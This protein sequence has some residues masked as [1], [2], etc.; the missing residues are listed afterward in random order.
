MEKSMGVK[1]RKKKKIA[2]LRKEYDENLKKKYAW[3]RRALTED[4]KVVRR[5][6]QTY[7]PSNKY[8]LTQSK[9]E[10]QEDK[11]AKT[12]AK[13]DKKRELKGKPHDKKGKNLRTRVYRSGP[14]ALKK[15]KLS[16]L[17]DRDQ[18]EKQK[19]EQTLDWRYSR[20]DLEARK[21]SDD[22]LLKKYRK[23]RKKS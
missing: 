18:W 5:H 19:F 1:L 22:R 10:K 14:F 16:R 20:A 13:K 6:R 23:Y 15:K 9:L 21:Q 11:V 4:E 17:R 12:M 8:L 2:S 3:P 7:K